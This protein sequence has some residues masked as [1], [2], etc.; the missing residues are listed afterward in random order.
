MI[1]VTEEA[2]TKL[3]ELLRSE[4][5]EKSAIRVAVMGGGSKS[6]GLGLVVDEAGPEDMSYDVGGI[7]LIIDRGLI[8]YCRSVTIDFTI[9]AEG[10]CGGASGSGF[11]IIPENP[12]NF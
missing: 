7:P 4:G 6:P 9:G 11:L 10:R 3:E 1:Q 12:V 5:G 8:D 2:L